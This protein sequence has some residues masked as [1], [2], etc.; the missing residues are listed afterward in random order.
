MESPALGLRVTLVRT[1]TEPFRARYNLSLRVERSDGCVASSDLF[2]DTG[3]ASR[4]NVYLTAS[5]ALV[6]MGAFDAR[7][8]PKGACTIRL[9]EFRHLEKEQT[10][11]GAFDSDGRHQWRYIPSEL[12]PE[13][14]FD[15]R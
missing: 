5:G 12:R 2:P 11:L 3:M 4:R 1:A 6:V 8:L 10:F 15:I 7:V 13:K 14:S 9:V